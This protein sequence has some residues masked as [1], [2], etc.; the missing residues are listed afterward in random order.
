MKAK[1]F[2]WPAVVLGLAVTISMGAGVSS[3]RQP[4]PSAQADKADSGKP[5]PK[6]KYNKAEEKAYKAFF[7][8]RT[9]APATQIKLGEEFVAKFPQSHYLAGVYGTLTTAY[10][11]TGQMDKMF[12]VGDKALEL[13]PDNV[14]VLPILAMAI[15]RRF[16]DT[17][18]DGAKELQKAEMYAHHAIE[19]IPNIPKP[20]NADEA[21]FEKAKNDKLSLAH[22]GLGLIDLNHQ[23]FEDAR[24][25]LTQA[26]TL[27]SSPDP[28]DYYLLGNADSGASYYNDA[29]VAYGKCSLSGPLASVCKA[30]A[31]AAKHDAE[32]KLGR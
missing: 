11:A 16:H 8:A 30:R 13:N 18:P 1:F 3:A 24:T 2:R 28:V 9:A 7:A 29:I 6:Y 19:L 22:S 21:S 25:E 12:A 4:S 10:F 20:A 17:T 23:K 27:A 15:P 32:T 14:D 31:A 26:V 5:A